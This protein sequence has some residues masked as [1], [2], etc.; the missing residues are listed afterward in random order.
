MISRAATTGNLTRSFKIQ[1]ENVTV[2]QKAHIGNGKYHRDVHNP[3][4]S[5]AQ[6]AF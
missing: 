1:T 6:N 3:S 4:F 2:I 5:I